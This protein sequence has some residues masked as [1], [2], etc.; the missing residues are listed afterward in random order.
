MIVFGYFNYNEN[1]YS[2]NIV[3]Q[4]KLDVNIIVGG[5]D[6]VSGEDGKDEVSGKAKSWF[7]AKTEI[8]FRPPARAPSLGRHAPFKQG[9][10]GKKFFRFSRDILPLNK[11]EQTRHKR[12]NQTG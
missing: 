7:V 10:G 11:H 8:G 1:V 6:E 5:K 9:G 12:T 2:M 3:R 4:R